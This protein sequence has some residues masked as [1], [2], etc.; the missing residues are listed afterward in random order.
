MITKM[1]Q[2]EKD[3]SF[4]LLL[5]LKCHCKCGIPGTLIFSVYKRECKW[6]TNFLFSQVYRSYF[7]YFLW[8]C[9]RKL[10]HGILLILTRDV[11]REVGQGGR[12]SPQILADQLTLPYLNQ[13][14]RLC[15][16]ITTSPKIFR[17]SDIPVSTYLRSWQ[18]PLVKLL[19]NDMDM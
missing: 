3:V 5:K 6:L 14:G 16:P 12:T 18:F 17:P 9:G 13:G 4:H 7:C 15:T 19:S 11:G 10:G 2:I 1:L 8:N